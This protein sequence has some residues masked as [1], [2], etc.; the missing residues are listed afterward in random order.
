MGMSELTFNPSHC[1]P[2]QLSRK[3][4]SMFHKELLL[5]S[6]C[7]LST[8]EDD[9]VRLVSTGSSPQRWPNQQNQRNDGSSAKA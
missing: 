5:T 6:R 9:G 7:A 3:A 8:L 1:L 4:Y 2:T